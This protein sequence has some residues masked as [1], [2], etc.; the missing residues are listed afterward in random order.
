MMKRVFSLTAVFAMAL[1]VSAFAVDNENVKGGVISGFLKKSESPY[2]VKET[3]VVPKGKALVVEPG[4]VVEFNDGTG[5][6]VRGGSLAIMGQTN[7]PVVFKAKGTFWNGI[8]VTGEKKT[9]IQDLQILNAEYGIAV[10]NGSLDLKSVTID[11]P[12]RIGLHVRNASVDAQWMTVSNGSNVGVWASENSK[13]KISSSNLNGNRMGL[14]VS[15]GADVN[16]QSTGIRQNDVGVFV[17]G[18]HQFSQRALVVEKNKIGLASQERPDPEFKNS[19]AKNNDRRLLRKTGMLESTLG[20]EPVNPYANAMVAMEAEANSED[21][22]K[23]SG[24]IV[25][26]LGHHWV[27]M[28]HNRSDDMIV[29]ED[30]IYHGDRYK[31]YF[32]VPG[33]F[34]NWI[35]SVVMESPTGKTIEISTDV[36]S[37]K[38]NSFNVH[39]FQA[40]YTDEYQKLVLGNLFANGGEISLAGI[41]VLGASYELELFKNAFKKHMFELSGFVGEAQAPK[42]IGTRDRDMYNEYIDDGEAVAQKMVAGTKIL[43]NIHRRFDG[44]LGFIGSKDYMNDPFLRDGMADDVNTASPIIASR[45]LFAEGNW[46]VYPGD[47]KLNG[48]VAVGVADTANAAAI[49]AMNSVFTSAGL[50]AS[51]F[52]LLNR[53]MKNPSAVNSLSQEQLESIFGDNSMMTVGDMKKKLQS[54]LAEAKAR[55]KE[56][57]PKDSRPSNP[58]FWNYKNWAIAGSFEWSNDNTFVEGYFKYVGAGYYSAGS[59]DMQQNTRLYG[60][61]LKQKITDFWKLNFGYDINIENADDGNG[62]YNIIGFGEGEKWGVAGADG[63][64]L[65]QHNQDE[66]RTLY[67]HNGYLTNEFKIL[68]NL[69]L[70]LKY[71]FDYRTRSTAT[72]LYPSFEAASGIYEDSWFKPRSGKSTMSFVENGDTIRIDAERWEKYRELQDEDYLASMFEENL[73]KHTID[74][75]V[76]YKF[77]KNVLKVGGTWVY[78]TDL[79]KFGEDGLLD[80]F[81]FSNKTYGILG[82]Y[83]HGG[84][85]FEQRYPVSLTTT[86]D[87]IRN[88]VSVMPRYKIYNRDDMTEFEWTLSD[89]MTIPVVKD[90]LDVSLNGNFRQN[91]LDRTV[92]GEDL[93]EME[94]DVDGAISLRFHHTAS[95]FTD[96]TLGAVYDYRPDNRADQY[97]DFYAIVSLNYSF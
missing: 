95:L 21:G 42:V 34:A 1:H 3:L 50:D 5:L 23:V 43:W 59:P 11:S 86:L 16:I 69:S 15:E 89:N 35:A 39:S 14:V 44:A 27:Y 90:F 61:N 75:A 19:V 32:Q 71:G 55:V 79:S 33:L 28:S 20:D 25:L 68:D 66:N 49:R 80:G 57:E 52:S 31:N 38:W 26:D 84:D 60:G 41:N 73:L 91:F 82:Y 76:T 74:L 51:D 85:Y 12:D 47:I 94:I 6:D 22:W 64:W 93:D 97:K 54:L 72:R 7:S 88:T 45:T 92:D 24:N 9:E 10:E 58:D 78:R 48:Q 2:L 40:S 13:L 62:G 67:I 36:S 4:V 70:S 8:S 46:L 65:K 87:F 56:F 37:D 29:G 63:K 30:T 81:N 96:W 77:P 83:F 17:Q 53:L 18:D